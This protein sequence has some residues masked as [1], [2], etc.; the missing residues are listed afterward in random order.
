MFNKESMFHIIIKSTALTLIKY[1]FYIFILIYTKSH[2][3]SYPPPLTVIYLSLTDTS[4]AT[5]ACVSM[6]SYLS[7]DPSTNDI[8]ALLIDHSV[9]NSPMPQWATPRWWILK[10]TNKV[11]MNNKA[12][13]VGCPCHCRTLEV[14]T[15]E[16]DRRCDREQACPAG[17]IVENYYARED[18]RFKREKWRHGDGK[19]D[20]VNTMKDNLSRDFN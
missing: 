2:K 10:H 15:A 8:L 20:E 9:T 7:P 16:S 11:Q 3:L 12:A 17:L 14:T 18:V 1:F 4:I 5:Y 13:I 19:Y 6:I